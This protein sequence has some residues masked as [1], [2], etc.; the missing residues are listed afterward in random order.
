VHSD[1]D[2]LETWTVGDLISSS[3]T[4]TRSLRMG[5]V[6]WKRSFDLRP[7]LLTFPSAALGGSAVVPSAVTLY[8]N[9]V[10]Q[11]ETAVPSG[12]FIINQVAGIN[13]AGQATLVTRDASR[14]A[15]STTLPLYVDTRM[16]AAGLTDYS[17]ELGVLRRRYTT[18]SFDYAQ[19]PAASASL[20]RG[21]SDSLTLE[22]HGEGGRAC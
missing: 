2:T 5:G 3:L 7:D 13:G 16:L 15:V 18:A 17:V 22:A 11:V 8:I 21:L 6:Q 14:R 4:W 19:T 1:P 12:P 10:R 9:G 20:R